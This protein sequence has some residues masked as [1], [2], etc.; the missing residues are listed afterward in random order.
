MINPVRGEIWRVD[1]DPSRGAE[2]QK[3]RP[4]VVINSNNTGRMPLRLI[5]PMT[6]WSEVFSA[7]FWMARVKAT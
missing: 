1:L 2:M 4:A 7:Y 5:L 3:T 6:G